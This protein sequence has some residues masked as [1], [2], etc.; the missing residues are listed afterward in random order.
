MTKPAKP[1]KA[2]RAGRSPEATAARHAAFV[3]AYLT[4]GHNAAAAA[5]AAGFAGKGAKTAGWKMLQKPDVKALLAVRAAHVADLADMS[6]ETW[7]TELR[8]VA[9]SSVGHLFDAAEQLVPIA[10]LPR[11]AQASI[12]AIKV[13]KDGEAIEYKFWDKTAALELMARHL[14]LFEKDNAQASDITVRV[15]LVG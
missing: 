8:A 7:A 2:T 5:L 11:H 1:P 10:R 15:E 9:F 13:S 3:D 6:V 12:S 4:N 14:G